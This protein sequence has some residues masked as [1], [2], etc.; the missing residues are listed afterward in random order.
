M[1]L[2]IGSAVV[3]GYVMSRLIPGIDLAT[4]IA[5]G[6]ILSPTDAV[7]TSIVK[8]AGV[9]SRLVTVLEGESLLND[10]AALV[11]LRSA[12][13]ATALLSARAV[14]FDFVGRGRRRRGR[15]RHRPL[16]PP[17]AQSDLASDR[18]ASRS[19]SWCRSSPTS[20]PSGSMRPAW[21]RPWSPGWSPAMGPRSTCV[22][23][24]G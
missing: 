3:I 10:A 22:R 15:L 19:R 18:A 6:A 7:A 13:A 5:L 8:R 1:L 23:R 2:V 14:A 4:G 24:I 17:G 9:S 21:W 12:T 11:L 16:E 20:R